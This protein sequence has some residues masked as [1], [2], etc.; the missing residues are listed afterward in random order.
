LQGCNILEVFSTGKGGLRMKILGLV[1]SHRRNGNSE[2]LAKSALMGAEGIGA[3]V[4]LLRL[5]DYR[6]EPC[7]GLGL[8][9]FREEGCHI[10]DDVKFIW[11]KIDA[12]DGILLSVPC[13]FLESTAVLK[14]LIDRAWVLAHRG[15][16]RGKYAS[17]MVPY[18]TRGWIP[19]AMLQPNI[20]CG[21]LGLNVIHRAT[22]NVQGLGEVVLDE[23]AMGRASRIGAELAHA[24]LEQ[25]P[26]YRS[27]GGLCP[28]CQDWNIRILKDR[29]A[30]ECP[31]CGIRGILQVRDER[32]EVVFDERAKAEYRFRPEVGY[33]HFTYHI[34][35][36]RDY[37]LRT[38]EERKS[39]ARPYREFL[40]EVR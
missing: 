11:S 29:K 10:E 37:F 40:R 19:Y 28:I 27:E 25:D 14:Q 7:Q 2:L 34:K 30:V 4:E 12:A 20:L 13:Y 26:T 36:S 24:V 1:G 9:L 23:D 5:T 35:P 17:L 22:F 8:C 21:I 38:K 16:F 31:T 15:T 39:K 6:I 18:A 33:N 32:I 3:Q